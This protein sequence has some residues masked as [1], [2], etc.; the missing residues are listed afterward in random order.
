YRSLTV[1]GGTAARLPV[2]SAA[3]SAWVQSHRRVVL[4][5]AESVVVP[6]YAPFALLRAGESA[7]ARAKSVG[8]EYRGRRVTAHGTVKVSYTVKQWREILADPEA[9][10]IVQG[11]TNRGLSE[12]LRR[13]V[14]VDGRTAT[15]HKVATA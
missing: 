2:V 3:V 8:A 14:T 5:D 4:G 1:A 7:L 13:E 10:V 6:D 11:R 9:W 15:V 12:S